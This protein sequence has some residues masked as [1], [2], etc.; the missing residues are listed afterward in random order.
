M[1]GARDFL[2]IYQGAKFNFHFYL[3][4]LCTPSARSMDQSTREGVIF[5]S[6]GRAEANLREEQPTLY[7]RKAGRKRADRVEIYETPR[8]RLSSR[9]AK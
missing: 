7:I 1:N 6:R 8:E 4:S 3:F 9:S 5:V 2:E